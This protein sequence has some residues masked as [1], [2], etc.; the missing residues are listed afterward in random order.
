MERP[1]IMSS[2]IRKID[3]ENDGLALP[4]DKINVTFMMLVTTGSET[5]ATALGGIMNYLTQNPEVLERVQN[6]VRQEL[7]Q[8]GESEISLDAL[9][10]LRYLNTVITEGLRLCTPIP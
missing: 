4:L 5:T 8:G 10:S 7:K 6:E 3:G 9:Q 2:M 1:D